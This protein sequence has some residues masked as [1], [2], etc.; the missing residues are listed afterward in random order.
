MMNSGRGLARPA[1]NV[2]EWHAGALGIVGAV[3]GIILWALV[4]IAL[5]LAIITLI[6][7]LREPRPAPPTGNMPPAV[8]YPPAGPATPAPQAGAAGAAPDALQVLEDRY[9]RGELNHDEYLER[10]R[11]LTAS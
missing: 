10:K 1:G 6:R 4:V 3:L 2:V 7:R 9:A 11:N 8:V 5:V